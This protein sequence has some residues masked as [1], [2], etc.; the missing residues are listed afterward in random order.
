MSL[1]LA[2]AGFVVSFRVL[3]PFSEGQLC[4]QAAFS[5]SF[6]CRASRWLAKPAHAPVAGF[7][8]QSLCEGFVGIMDLSVPGV[9]R[10]I[11]SYPCKSRGA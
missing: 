8:F 7:M 11:H 5:F 3:G 6:S 2:A 9:M 4:L 1:A 10:L